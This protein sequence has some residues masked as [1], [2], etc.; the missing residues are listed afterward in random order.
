MAPSIV[1]A[2]GRP[3][4]VLGSAGSRRLRGAILQVAVNVVAHGL[5]VAEALERPRVH[6]EDTVV[7]CEGG[8]ESAELERLEQSGYPVVRWT[9][10]NL[11]FGGVA[12][13]ETRPDGSLAAAGD[14]RRGGH[15]LVIA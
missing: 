11:F 5:G 12:A 14:S 8:H 15:G 1:L 6:A 2:D 10:R 7:H 3:R 13:V 9:D 4:L